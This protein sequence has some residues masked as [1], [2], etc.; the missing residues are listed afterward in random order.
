LIKQAQHPVALV[1]SQLRWSVRREAYPEFVR[2][3]G[4]PVYGPSA[5]ARLPA[6][7]TIRISSRTRKPALLS[8]PTSS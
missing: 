5:W 7:R 8:A 1:G 3:F 2:T 4:M 6:A